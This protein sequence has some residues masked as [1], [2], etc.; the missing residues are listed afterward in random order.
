MIDALLKYSR[1]EQQDLPRQRF[2][3]SGII[4]TLS[5]TDSAACR[6][7]SRRSTL[8][9]PSPISMASRSV[10]VRRLPDLLDNAAKFA[11]RTGSPTITI[12]GTQTVTER[13]LWVQDNGI[14]FDDIAA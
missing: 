2:N 3:S 10:S 14:G 12:G 7:Q 5:P 11:R 1:L 9:C 13:V 8:N 6:A 4:T